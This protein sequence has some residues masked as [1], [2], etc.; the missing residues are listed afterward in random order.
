MDNITFIN[1]ISDFLYDL[2][3][4]L[5]NEKINRTQIKLIIKR[6]MINYLKKSIELEEILNE[7]IPEWSLTEPN[8][9]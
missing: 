9:Q 1:R 4:C 6:F 5:D 7:L 2:M 8:Y 3:S